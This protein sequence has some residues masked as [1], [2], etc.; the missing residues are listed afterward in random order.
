MFPLPYK[1]IVIKSSFPPDRA[2]ERISAAVDP[3]GS[4]FHCSRAF[5]GTVTNKGFRLVVVAEGKRLRPQAYGE[6][7]PT[8]SG[9][10]ADVTFSLHPYGLLPVVILPLV[11]LGGDLLRGTLTLRSVV[12]WVLFLLAVDAL[13]YIGGFRSTVRDAERLLRDL[14]GEYD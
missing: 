1:R 3:D 12:E 5:Y 14:L 4:M 9:M 10:S 13:V 11:I 6:F 8:E 7:V 2:A